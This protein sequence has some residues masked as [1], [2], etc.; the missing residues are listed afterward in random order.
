MLELLNIPILNVG[1]F[2][3]TTVRDGLCG[4]STLAV[5]E[6]KVPIRS[7]FF[8]GVVSAIYVTHLGA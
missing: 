6:G 3:T 4:F 2:D 1:D 7:N 8:A 5:E